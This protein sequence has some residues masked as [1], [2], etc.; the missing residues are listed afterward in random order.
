[1]RKHICITA[2]ILIGLD[3][4][5]AAHQQNDTIDTQQLKEVIVEGRMQS[6]SAT[7]STYIPTRRQKNSAQTAPELLNHMA[8]PQLGL[9]SGNNVTTTSGQGVDLF[10]DYVPASEQDLNGLRM[11]DVNRVEYYDY[12]QDPRFQGKPHVINFIMQKYEYGGYVKMYGND[13]LIAN[14]GQLNL[15]SKFQ[16]K[17]MTYD[18]AVGAWYSN[19]DHMGDATTE[20][21]RLP[22]KDGSIIKF[23]R[24][25]SPTDTKSRQRSLWPTFKAMYNTDRITMVNTIGANF[26]FSPKQNSGG[27]V[28]YI[29]TDFPS[30]SYI[31]HQNS[32]TNSITYS[33]Y[34]NFI[35]PH[36]NSINFNP[37]YSYSHTR[38]HSLYSETNKASF[39]NNA[40][41]D[42]HRATSSLR[43]IHDFGN[44]GNLST[45]CNL[46]YHANRTHYSGTSNTLDHLTTFR[47]GPGMFYNYKNDTF[48]GLLGGGFNYDHSRY[49][50]EKEHSIQPWIDASIQYSFNNKN[51]FNTE[52][53][54][55]T[56]NPASSYRSTAMIMSNPLLSYTGN[57]DLKPYRNYDLTLRYVWMPDNKWNMAVFGT[58]WIVKD[59]F[60]YVYEPSSTGIIRTIRQDIGNYIQWYYG[61]TGTVRLLKNSLMVNGQISHRIVRNGMPYDW[62]KHG[63]LWY[64]Q[65]FYYLKG[66]NFGIQYQSPQEYCDGYMTG[67]WTKTKSAY[68]AIIG[69]GNSDWNI[70]GKITN[71]FRW[72]WR[73]GSSE[74]KSHS[75]DV[76]KTFYNT[77]YHCYILVSA[78]YTF[79][80]G[81]KI[82]RGNEASQQMGT[83]SSILN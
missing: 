40:V 83:S 31:N 28:L 74:M 54:Y 22:Q 60:A 36:G 73:A 50:N 21:Y 56:W 52:F 8:I 68:T 77:S 42:S 47:I 55:S 10:I 57:P 53:H 9:V 24:I 59:R 30:T 5:T 16:Y 45:I 38:Q 82:Q 58:G 79:G 46:Y 17:K 32:R 25:F 7:K 11:N 63:I 71:P 27:T 43:F 1:M 34:W 2:I 48:N 78:T 20:Q 72:N 14:T 66:W 44:L 18:I 23:N 35:L 3:L 37:Y 49:N 81:R 64:I 19:N 70:Q 12:P 62:T 75:Y 13:F 65:S 33:G 4:S 80:F 29:P 51:S 61:V 67:A 69:W 15:F 26:F 41:D 76:V 6:T 39:K